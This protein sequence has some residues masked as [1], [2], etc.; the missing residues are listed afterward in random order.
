MPVKP[1]NLCNISSYPADSFIRGYETARS[2]W[3]I[4][5]CAKCALKGPCSS[6]AVFKNE[7]VQLSKNKEE[8]SEWTSRAAAEGVK[9]GRFRAAWRE[10]SGGGR[11]AIRMR[12][13]AGAGEDDRD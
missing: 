4:R 10:R 5:P 1:S 7:M 8:P 11:T 3:I 12:R 9:S 13:E 6:A 2:L